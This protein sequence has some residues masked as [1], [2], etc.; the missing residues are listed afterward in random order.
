M[1]EALKNYEDMTVS[2]KKVLTYIVENQSVIPH[3]MINDLSEAT[4]VSKTVIINL[5]QKLGFTGY[6]EM[7]Y[8]INQIMLDKI[9]EQEVSTITHR[10]TLNQTIDKT[11]SLV[12]EEIL[13]NSAEKIRSSNNVFVMARGT[14]K[15]AG[16]YLEHFLL[17]IGIQC[18]FIKDYN[19]SELFP[20]FLTE[21]DMVIF[22]SMS[23]S[24][25]KIIDTAKKVHLRNANIIN[26]TSFQTNELARYTMNNLY[27]YSDHFN[28]TNN[29]TIS[30]IGFFLIIDMMINKL[31]QL[32]DKPKK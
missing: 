12:T 15:A 30:R 9:T 17:S 6:R 7:K 11:F 18:I 8:H 5:A 24:T 23:G 28:T 10:E 29:D 20:E 31:K 2:E 21:D 27:C 4:Y 32:M 25:K 16:Y 26:I 1:F 19:L 22:I 3:M 14:S 13:H